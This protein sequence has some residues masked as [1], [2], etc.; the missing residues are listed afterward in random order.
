MFDVDLRWESLDWCVVS[1]AHKDNYGGVNELKRTSSARLAVHELDARVIS[2]FDERLVLA[3]KDIDTYW[4]RAGVSAARRAPLRDMYKASKALFRA[5]PVDR[6]RRAGDVIGPGYVVHHVPG[7]WPGLICL[8]VHDVLLTSDHVLARI[9]PHQFPQAITPFAGLEHY[10][11]SLAK[12]RALPGIRLALGGHEE[13]IPDMRARIDE[14]ERFHRDRLEQVLGVCEVARSVDEISS[15][16]F[17]GQEGYG[18]ILAIEE[19]G[20]HVEY[21]HQLGR[22]RVDNLAEVAASDDP[23]FRYVAR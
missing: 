19:A 14:I 3:A 1:H 18:V 21:L 6:A 20:A 9:T 16:M 12:V 11:R 7:H 22:L 5:E 10:F 17:G 23:V 2:R 13:P 15:A 8:Q 4:R